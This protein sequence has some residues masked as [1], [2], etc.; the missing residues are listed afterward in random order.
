MG[1]E[2]LD[3]N[4]GDLNFF[5]ELRECRNFMGDVT[6]IV[7]VTGWSFQVSLGEEFDSEKD[8]TVRQQVH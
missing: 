1:K 3:S 7:A 5:L 8:W 2:S 6:R 4:K